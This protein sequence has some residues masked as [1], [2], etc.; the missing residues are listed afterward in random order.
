MGLIGIEY[1]I[2]SCLLAFC[3]FAMG[4]PG[5]QPFEVIQ[6]HNI[7]RYL[8]IHIPI[9]TLLAISLWNW[10]FPQIEMI[11]VQIARFFHFLCWLIF[12]LF[13]K[14]RAGN[15]IFD[16]IVFNFNAKSIR[17]KGDISIY[18]RL[19][20]ATLEFLWKLLD[21]SFFPIV[22]VVVNHT[23]KFLLVHLSN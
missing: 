17:D 2:E 4:L 11:Q 9:V 7:P 12:W 3:T 18:G 19:W 16:N 5:Q 21:W 1:L 14:E 23:D 15:I 6:T 13:D 20:F 10:L 8:R 22:I